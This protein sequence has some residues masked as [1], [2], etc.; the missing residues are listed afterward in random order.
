MACGGHTPAPAPVAGSAPPRQP[1]KPF[2]VAPFA[3]QQ[4]AVIPITLVVPID[5][6]ERVAP[7]TAHATAIAWADSVVGAA[8]VSR[9]PEVKWALP[10][11]LRKVARRAPTVAP[12]PDRMGQSMM[13]EHSLET[14]PDPLRSNLRS[15]MALLNGRFVFIP[16][17]VAVVPD[18]GGLVRAEITLVLADTRTGKVVWRTVSWGVAST[19]NRALA[20]AMETVLPL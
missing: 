14:V 3:G 20:V 12:D 13:R 6:M 1:I 5:T 19:P 17:A 2:G 11:E 10:P 4:I 15:L 9:G 18:K 16:A 7:F 8:L